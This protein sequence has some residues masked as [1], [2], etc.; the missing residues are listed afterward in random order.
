[1]VQN[2]LCS[3]GVL[4]FRSLSRLIRVPTSVGC[5]TLESPGAVVLFRIPAGE[6]K[7]EEADERLSGAGAPQPWSRPDDYEHHSSLQVGDALGLPQ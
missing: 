3:R 1:M 5:C 7:D 6:R 4:T 2:A